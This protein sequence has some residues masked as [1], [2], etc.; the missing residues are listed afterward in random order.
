MVL[1]QFK[2]DWNDITNNAVKFGQGITVSSVAG[3]DPSIKVATVL[4][5]V[6]LNSGEY[7]VRVVGVEIASGLVNSTTFAF[8]PQILTITSPQFSFP[9]GATQG[10]TFTNNGQ[11]SQSDIQGERQFLCQVGVGNIT[12]NLSLAQFGTFTLTQAAAP[13]VYAPTATWTTSGFAY[14]L[15]SLDFENCDNK[16]LYGKAK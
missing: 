16:A 2:I 1:I 10:L 12:L 15:L 5:N 9:A 14:L 7:I 4:R 8:Q 6:S 3:G 13:Y 11:Y